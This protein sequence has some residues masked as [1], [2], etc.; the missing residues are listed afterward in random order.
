MCKLFFNIHALDFA[1][2]DLGIH[3]NLNTSQLSNG[4]GLLAN[5][6]GV[7]GAVDDNSLADLLGLFRIQEVAATGSEFLLHSIIHILMNNNGLFGSTNHAVIESLRV[8]DGVNSHYNIRSVIDDSGSIAGA[9]TQSR[10]TGRISGLYHARTT[11]CQNDVSRMHQ[12]IGHFQRR[13]VNPTDDSLRCA[14]CHS[15]VQHN[16]RSS[17]G[18][19]LSAGM[20]ADD[21]AVAGFQANQGLEDSGG[22]GVRGGDNRGHNTDRLGN[23]SHAKSLVFFYHAAGL[24]IFVL[25]VNVLSCI[26]VLNNLVFY[27]THAGLFNGHLCQRDTCLVGCDCCGLEDFVYLLL[28]VSGKDTLGFFYLCHLG[29]ESVKII[30]QTGGRGLRGYCLLFCLHVPVLHFVNKQFEKIDCCH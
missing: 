6:L 19:L 14:C 17:D 12:L 13:N 2:E 25:I 29:D 4:V 22:S 9:D 16:L 8:N 5:D 28:R 11:G 20:G 18:A 7:Y 21:N 3:R 24:G 27:N 26:V 30:Y 10:L 23:L 15:S 1:D